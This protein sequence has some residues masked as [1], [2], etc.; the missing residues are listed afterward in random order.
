MAYTTIKKPT[1]YFNT[2]LYTGTG[3]SNAITGVEFQ[4]DFTWLKVRSNGTYG[5]ALFDAV[6]GVNKSLSSNADS[7]EE[8]DATSGNTSL[9]SF[10]S[11]GFTLG[12]FYNKVNQ[13]GQT[14]A[15]WNFKANG[16][17]SANSDGATA[18]TVSANTT[19]GFSCVKWTGTGSATTVGHGLGA[20]PKMIIV[21]NLGQN[22]DWRVGHTNIAWTHRLCLNS[23]S[24]ENNDDSAWNDTAPTSSVFTVGSSTCTNSSGY[25]MIAYVFTEKV[26]YSKFSKYIGNGNA[27]GTFVYTGFKPALVII[28]R[29]DADKNWYTNDIKRDGYNTD[30]PYLSPNLNA[31]ETGGTELDL[32]SNGFK[33]RAS[34]TGHNSDGATYIYMA[35]AAEPIVGD[36]PA[37]AR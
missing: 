11:D 32:L 17:G 36:S 3:S 1:D 5:H 34:G 9:N 19:S 24:P 35:I 10:D 30:N 13:S 33:I 29:A 14:F 31:A 27:D 6:R 18:S 15:S 12:G 37:T 23:G 8:N 26:G 28:K 4:P 21:K 7:A 16:A 20:V 25:E 2:K 22:L